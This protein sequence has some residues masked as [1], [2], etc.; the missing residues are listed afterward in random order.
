MT[1]SRES[2]E[3]VTKPKHGKVE[4][5]VLYDPSTYSLKGRIIGILSVYCSIN[6]T[7]F[8]LSFYERCIASFFICTTQL[9]Y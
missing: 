9:L 1:Y 7:V 3:D 2:G 6:V 5:T 4:N 8:I